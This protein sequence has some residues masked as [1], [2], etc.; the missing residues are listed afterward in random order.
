M[1]MA[2][3]RLLIADAEK[4]PVLVVFEN[5]ETCGAETINLIQYLAAGVRDH[6]VV[7]IATATAAL[8]ERHPAFGDGEVA[9]Q[10]FDLGVLSPTEAEELLRELCKQLPDIPP[11]L[12]MHVR[13]LGGSPRAIHELVRLLLESDVI[14]RE[15]MMWRLDAERRSLQTKLPKSYDEVVAARLRV[16]EPT[17][18]RVLEMAAAIGETSWLDAILAVERA[19][20]RDSSA[21]SRQRLRK[22]ADPDGPTLSQI[23]A[24]GDHSRQTVVAAIAKL[25]EREWLV[26]VPTSSIAGERELRFAYP[27]LVGRSSI[28]RS[29]RRVAARI[30]AP[31]R[32]GSSCTPKGAARRRRKRSPGTSRSPARRA[33]PRSAIAAPPSTRA[34]SSRTSARSGC[35][36]ARS[37]ARATS[38]PGDL[39]TRIH[40]WHDLGSIYELIGDFEAALGAFERMLRLSWIFASKTKAAVAFNKMG[41]VWRRKGDLRLALEYLERGLELFRSAADQRGIASSLDDIGKSLQMLGRYD[42]AF[43]KITEALARRGKSGDKRSIATSRCRGSAT[44]RP[45]AATTTPRVH[46]SPGGARAAQ[47]RPAIAGAPRSRSTTSPRSRSTSATSPTRAP[48]GSPRCPRPRASARCRSRR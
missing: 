22:I 6:R 34:R 4:R 9:P 21:A 24:S 45:T 27:N 20:Q 19:A 48:A 8:F 38:E 40:L 33:R 2:L 39:A 15:G 18:R 32:A 11:S 44:C 43:A 29:T 16:M 1:F 25:V 5:L 28:A 36:T 42:E 37:R 17:E 31:S 30:T 10:R 7:L 13:G 47:G 35:S 46:V 41:R 26:E 3:K 23:A 12:V 14:V